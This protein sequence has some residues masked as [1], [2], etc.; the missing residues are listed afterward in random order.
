MQSRQPDSAPDTEELS[1]FREQWRQEVEQRRSVVSSQ[2]QAGISGRSVPPSAQTVDDSLIEPHSPLAVLPPSREHVSLQESRPVFADQWLRSVSTV[3]HGQHTGFTRAQIAAIDVYGRAVEA[4]TDSD[5]ELALRLYQ[6]A[7]RMYNDV[8]RL[9][10]KAEMQVRQ[11]RINDDSHKLS[12][13]SSV[14]STVNH[15]AN[16]GITGLGSQLEAVHLQDDT[17][18]LDTRNARIHQELISRAAHTRSVTGQVLKLVNAFPSNIS[19]EP[20]NERFGVVLNVLPEEVLVHILVLLWDH[21]SV[22]RFALVCRKARIVSLDSTI[23]R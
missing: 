12:A 13:T 6:Q 7:F 8:D 5:I 18:S 16:K 9:W 11:Q 19:F 20:D 17:T 15:S 22:E 4:E 23:W 3:A 2:T 14:P 1:R 21:S 10:R